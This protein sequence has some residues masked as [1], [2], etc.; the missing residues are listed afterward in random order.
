MIIFQVQKVP[1]GSLEQ[2]EAE[3]RLRDELLYREEVDR[4]IGKIAKLL[5]SEKDVAAGLSSVVL[6]EREGEPLVDDWE[7]FKSMLRTYEE[8]CGALTH[9]GRKY[10]R[11]MANMCNAGINQDQLT[12]AST[13]ACS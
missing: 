12:W 13:K 6:P 2:L 3:K 1:D 4:K 8:R 11:V 5:L 7:C 9:Y 10:S